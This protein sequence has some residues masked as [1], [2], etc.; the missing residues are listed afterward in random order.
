MKVVVTHEFK[1]KHTGELHKIGSEL[2]LQVNRVNEILKTGN[3]IRISEQENGNSAQNDGEE[4][5]NQ[6]KEE[7]D[8]SQ[9][10]ADLDKEEA[11]KQTSKRRAKVDK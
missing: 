8:S 3:F 7:P 6:E 5:Q 11:P 10:G 1:D 2:D 4:D 9:N